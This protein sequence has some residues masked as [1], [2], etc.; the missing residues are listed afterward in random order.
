VARLARYFVEGQPQHSI[1]RGNDRELIF[2][3]DEDYLFFVECL[4][5]AAK[6]H[7]C[8]I[9]AYVSMTNHTHLLATPET[10][11]SLPKTI[12]LNPVRA[13]MVEEPLHYR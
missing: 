12:E 8:A 1:Q 7:R 4:Q 6:R 3:A 13:G 9:H 5:N 2:A 10:K 11:S